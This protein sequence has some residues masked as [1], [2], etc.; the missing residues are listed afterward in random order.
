MAPLFTRGCDNI[1]QS[2]NDGILSPKFLNLPL[3]WFLFP[4]IQIEL[5][6]GRF[7]Y[8]NWST[9]FE[10]MHHVIEDNSPQLPTDVFS[11]EFEYFIELW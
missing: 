11:E 7:P 1:I 3:T 2:V 6:T 8:A 10:I 9:P 5:A 4:V